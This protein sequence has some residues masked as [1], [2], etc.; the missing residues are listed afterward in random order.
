MISIGPVI[1]FQLFFN[2]FAIYIMGVLNNSKFQ[3]RYIL[4]Q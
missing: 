3:Q 2:Y 1:L 4:L